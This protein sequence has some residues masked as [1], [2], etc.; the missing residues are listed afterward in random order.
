MRIINNTKIMKMEIRRACI[1]R[2]PR[3]DAMA[4]FFCSLLSWAFFGEHFLDVHWNGF[5]DH[6]ICILHNQ[7][8]IMVT[9]L[10]FSMTSSAMSSMSSMS[11]SRLPALKHSVNDGSSSGFFP[12]H[13]A[14]HLYQT[15]NPSRSKMVF[16][17]CTA[18][19]MSFRARS[20]HLT[21]QMPPCE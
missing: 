14:V 9:F 12:L 1:R 6:L 13:F 16:A 17:H 3:K 20:S 11:K 5:I 21:W 4:E 15:L 10:E 19:D 8:K 18:F 7:S 2:N